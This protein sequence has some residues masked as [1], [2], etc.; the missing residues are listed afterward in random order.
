MG[1]AR[2]ILACAAVC[3]AVAGCSANE[4]RG[5][6][7]G[8]VGYTVTPPAGWQDITRSV[9][10]ESGVAFDVAYGGPTVDGRRLNVNVARREAGE[11]PSLERL[12]R[13]GRQEVD[14]LADGKLDF[15]PWVRTEVDG[16]PALRY[17]FGA[18]G[19]LVRQIGTVHE[20]GYYVVT[21]TAPKPA[22]G[23][24]VGMLEQ[25]LR[26]WRWD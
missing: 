11:E 10:E 6:A 4:E 21:L 20:G 19:A 17:D 9:E 7:R 1:R 18:N 5:S 16:A 22:F 3:A 2:R 12:V 13:Q 14:E 25:M 26:S 15:S 24:A 23:R 8:T